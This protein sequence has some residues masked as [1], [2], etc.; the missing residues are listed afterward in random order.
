MDGTGVDEMGSDSLFSAPGLAPSTD[1]TGM[2]LMHKIVSKT[3][4]DSEMSGEPTV[5]GHHEIS[6]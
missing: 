3:T 6:A 4:E 2:D 5:D 1:E